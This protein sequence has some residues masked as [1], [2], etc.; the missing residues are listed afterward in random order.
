MTN[1]HHQLIPVLGEL[2]LP[3]VPHKNQSDEPPHPVQPV[4]LLESVNLRK[5]GAAAAKRA[6]DVFPV[7]LHRKATLDLRKHLIR[8]QAPV[9]NKG[10]QVLNKARTQNRLLQQAQLSRPRTGKEQPD[11]LPSVSCLLPGLAHHLPKIHSIK[12]PLI[13][14]E[15]R[16]HDTPTTATVVMVGRAD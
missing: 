8:T 12:N 10:I 1:P 16:S 11:L 6:K 15:P 13:K 2:H 7:F 14:E 9:P 4:I 3:F 5:K